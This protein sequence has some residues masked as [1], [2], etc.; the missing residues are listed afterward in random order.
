M[1]GKKLKLK[2]GEK[3]GTGWLPPLPD[4]RDYS[5]E[6]PE[7]S[8]MSKKLGVSITK[9]KS[10]S[11]PDKV[12]LWGPWFSKIK[13]EDQCELGSCTANA[14]AGIIEYFELRSFGKYI[15]S[16]RLFIYKTTRNLMGEIGDTGAWLRTTMG[17]LALCGVAP[18]AYWPYTDKHPDFDEEPTPFVYATA[19][20]FE[21]LKYFCHDPIGSNASG[22][23]VI[24]SLKNYLAAG[25]P[26]MFGF[27]GFPSFDY[28][29]VEGGIPFP[30]PGEKAQWGHAIVAVG[31][32]DSKRIKNTFCDKTT[33]GAFL[34]R[35]SWGES[36]G[37]KGYG[38]LPYKYVMSGLALDF[39]SILGMEW[40]ETNQFGL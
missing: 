21:T 33:E 22:N 11:L 10:S 37:D 34:I 20:N 23:S 31:Y 13:I 40:L 19:D 28:T 25:I 27:W 32:D 35:N 29:D 15:D 36:W 16:S 17:A 7:I 2:S 4:L 9:K 12:D 3:V 5:E 24:L 1:Y 18:E 14:A 26:S 6:H 30:C 38:W 39:W 8:E